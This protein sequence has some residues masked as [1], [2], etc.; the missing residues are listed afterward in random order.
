MSTYSITVWHRLNIVSSIPEW[1]VFVTSI[2]N[3]LIVSLQCFCYTLGGTGWGRGKG[4]P[5]YAPGVE[6]GPDA[7]KGRPYM[8][9]GPAP[10][11]H[12]CRM[13]MGGLRGGKRKM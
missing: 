4:H 10:F 12:R 7:H 9:A 6:W 1:G 8:S 13:L 5:G 3:L 2:R 11:P